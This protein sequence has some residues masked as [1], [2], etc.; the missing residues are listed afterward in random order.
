MQSRLACQSWSNQTCFV[1]RNVVGRSRSTGKTGLPPTSPQAATPTRNYMRFYAD[2]GM[3]ADFDA[4]P[5]LPLARH[6][7]YSRQRA[8]R[9]A[10]ACALAPPYDQPRPRNAAHMPSITSRNRGRSAMAYLSRLPRYRRLRVLPS[11]LSV[12]G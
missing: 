6:A 3:I 8:Q 2:I 4:A 5:I 11:E 1:S 7:R 9:R 10:S 12:A